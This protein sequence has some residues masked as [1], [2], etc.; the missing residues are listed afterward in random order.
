MSS[1]KSNEDIHKK[2]NG[3][4]YIS[5]CVKC[6]LTKLVPNESLGI[7]IL[8]TSHICKLAHLHIH[9]VS[10]KLIFGENR[11]P[12]KYKLVYISIFSYY[13]G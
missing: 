1:F 2:G 9:E 5:A 13:S 11:K 4:Y 3:S 8:C 10:L 7:A 6:R 12:I